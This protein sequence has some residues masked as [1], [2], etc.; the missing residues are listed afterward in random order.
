[1]WTNI[2]QYFCGFGGYYFSKVKKTRSIIVP[3]VLQSVNKE[4]LRALYH[5][6]GWGG[7]G[8]P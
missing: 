5:A 2:L 4:Y 1:M 7:G 6:G 8:G 3:F